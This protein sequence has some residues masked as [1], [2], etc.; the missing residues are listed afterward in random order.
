MSGLGSI[1]IA[2]SVGVLYI[3]PSVMVD[4]RY[5]VP[6]DTL[7]YELTTLSNSVFVGA[8]T[9]FTDDPARRAVNPDGT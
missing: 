8:A 9:V 7:T 5:A 4:E 6:N 3:G 2:W 1:M